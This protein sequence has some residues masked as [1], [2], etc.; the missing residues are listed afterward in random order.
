MENYGSMKKNLWSYEKTMVLWKKLWYRGKK[1]LHRMKS[2]LSVDWMVTEWW[3][4]CDWMLTEEVDFS[5]ISATIQSPFSRL[6]DE[7]SSCLKL[8]HTI[9]C[10]YK[11]KKTKKKKKKK[12][13]KKTGTLKFYTRVHGDGEC[14][15]Q[16]HSVTIQ[17]P[18]SYLTVSL[19]F[20]KLKLRST[21]LEPGM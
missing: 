4:N 3:L 12:R 19:F 5:R 6:K 8:F 16:S 17:L 1:I 18:F 11:N 10:K 14:G 7:M 21:R 13:E 15:F 2:H 9:I 20:W